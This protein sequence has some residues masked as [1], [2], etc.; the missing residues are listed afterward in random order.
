MARKKNVERGRNLLKVKDLFPDFNIMDYDSSLSKNLSFYN[1]E[2]DGAAK[3]AFALAYWKKRNVDTKSISRLNDSWFSTVGAIAHMIDD[4]DIAIDE[5]DLLFINKKYQELLALKKDENTDDKPTLPKAD[6]ENRELSMHIAEFEYAIDIL[7]EGGVAD[8]KAYLLR[9][10]V[11][12]TIAKQIALHFKPLL[13]ELKEIDNDEQLQEAYSNFSKRELKTFKEGVHALVASCGVVSAIA[14]A[15][16]A[17]R[18]RKEKSPLLV[19]KDVKYLKEYTELKLC[20]VPPEKM[21]GASEIWLFNVKV[22]RLFRYVPL[23][24]MRLSI[25][26]TTIL[27]FDPEKSGGKIIRKPESQLKDIGM[28]TTRPINKL[29]NEIRAV[30]SKATG[31]INDECIIVRC[32]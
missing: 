18:T 20:S 1:S 6:I 23:D 30:A 9:N 22:R 3:K 17:P 2:V 27:N 7:L 25:K 11:K 5:K 16:R 32:L 10:E 29:Y 31:R 24:G 4:R 12:P 26:G 15:A 14:R 13:K 8:G 21:V 28:M 19:V